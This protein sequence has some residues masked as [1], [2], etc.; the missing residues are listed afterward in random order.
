MKRIP[1]NNSLLYKMK[2]RLT[3]CTLFF[4]ILLQNID[5]GCTLELGVVLTCTQKQCFSKNKKNKSSENCFLQLKKICSMHRNAFVYNLSQ[6]D[7][8]GTVDMIDQKSRKFYLD[9]NILALKSTNRESADNS[10]RGH[11]QKCPFIF[12]MT[13]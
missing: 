4:F 1:Q 6:S 10:G 13:P 9:V 8:K 7:M 12:K 5:C 3:G 11:G 2:K